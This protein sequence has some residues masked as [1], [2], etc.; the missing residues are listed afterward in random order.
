MIFV[1][2][3]PD[4]KDEE[5]EDDDAINDGNDDGEEGAPLLKSRA[6]VDNTP[7]Y[8]KLTLAI[9]LLVKSRKMQCLSSLNLTFGLTSALVNGYINGSIA[10]EAI[11]GSNVGYISAVLPATAA[12]LSIP[13]G[14]IGNRIGKEPI[15][16]FGIVNYLILAVVIL[17]VSFDSFVGM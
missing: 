7:W 17:S 5:A 4:L 15:M 8:N 10:K 11:G 6:A 9:N 1:K 16:L 13:Y 12:I 14:Y 2:D 3:P